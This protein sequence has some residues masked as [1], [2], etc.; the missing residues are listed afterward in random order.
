MNDKQ[1]DPDSTPRFRRRLRPEFGVV[2][3]DVA[4]TRLLC[5]GCCEVLYA[6]LATGETGYMLVES[7]CLRR[8]CRLWVV[9]VYQA[10]GAAAPVQLVGYAALS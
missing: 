9:F 10:T 2:H 3:R 1:P 6:P 8:R 7:Q 5:P 4:R